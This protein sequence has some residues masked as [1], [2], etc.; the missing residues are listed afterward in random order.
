M[1]NL[2]FVFDSV[3][4]ITC[5]LIC[6]IACFAC[7]LSAAERAKIGKL[8]DTALQEAQSHGAYRFGRTIKGGAHTNGSWSGGSLPALA[9]AGYTGNQAAG[10]ECV[11][12]MKKILEGKNSPTAT[13]GYPAQHELLFAGSAVILKNTPELW[14]LFSKT[15][16]EKIDLVV[17]ALLVASAYTTSDTNYTGGA[18]PTCMHGGSNFHRGWNPNFREGMIG[19]LLV[20]GCY[21]G[22]KEAQ[23]ILDTYKHDEFVSKLNN[24]GLSNTHETFTFHQQQ[25]K[26]PTGKQIEKAA[27]QFRYLG[28]T[29]HDPMGLYEGLTRNTFGKTVHAGLNDG[30]GI[31]GAGKIASGAD[32]LPN[33]G[34]PGM[35]LEFDSRDAGG[36]RSSA[37]Y[38]SHG[39]RPNLINQAALICS[40]HWK[41]GKV[42]NELIA[43]IDVG[44]T[45]LH[46]KLKYGYL[47][48]SKGK[49]SKNPTTLDDNR[50]D[51]RLV[52]ALWEDVLKPFHKQKASA[53][54]SKKN[55]QLRAKPA[56][57]A[58]SIDE[59]SYPTF[60]GHLQSKLDAY[61]KTSKRDVR[62]TSSVL[63][64]EVAIQSKEGSNYKLHVPKMG[65][66]MTINI[67]K[68]MKKSDAL[69]LCKAIAN[70]NAD[71]D[72]A[73]LS[74]FYYANNDSVNGSFHLNKA[75]EHKELV[76]QHLS[77]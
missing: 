51:H 62:Y 8:S 45:D 34:K 68:K 6:V 23:E 31:K 22:P 67:F 17:K 57:Q 54:K 26:A 3:Y 44:A 38:A 18:K 52:H 4:K 1:N 47:N 20:A 21:F 77:K 61:M 55:G 53:Q 43:L 35:L 10:S 63:K 16:Q 70:K 76:N 14:T 71:H 73:L 25:S 29:I 72:N 24:A 9:L 27:H 65:T 60:L 42:A 75:G 37:G 15:E 66:T 74:Y 2:S 5:F 69:S 28:N 41:K 33:I 46:Y 30:K 36:A 7:A 19:M 59:S 64:Q 13:G 39:F 32:G 12:R 50:F 56:K 40:G 48:Y 58:K 49:A 11:N